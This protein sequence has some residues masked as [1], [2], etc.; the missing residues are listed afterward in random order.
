MPEPEARPGLTLPRW[1]KYSLGVFVVALAFYFLLSRLLRDWS[2]IPFSELHFSPWLLAL[3][4][5]VLIGTHLPLA[6][7]AW[8]LILKGLGEP[9]D[10]GR[11]I[12]VM[13]VTQLGKYVPG[14]LWF[15]LGR[16]SLLKSDSI[17]EAKTMVSVVVEI[18]LSLLAA[19]VLL[20]CAVILT[21]RA[22]V[23]DALYLAFLLVPVC[24]IVV[25]PRVLNRVLAY[26]LRRLKQP[27]FELRLTYRQLLA[28]TGLYL[29]DWTLQGVGSFILLNSFYPL[30]ITRL[31]VVLGGY[32]IS[33]MVGFLALVAPAGLGIREGIFTLI[34]KIVMPGP[35]AIIF[36]LL[37]RVWMTVS[38]AVVALVC[39]PLLN[40]RRRNETETQTR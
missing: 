19:L 5:A 18:V 11:A 31:P 3:S 34:L 13:S 30:P 25:Y 7:S 23:P 33:W 9:L 40:R 32:A 4:F 12:A 28:I 37:T 16:M 26:A 14:K 24:V 1:L 17:P 21:P 10:L 2:Q 39:L 29:A 38:E 22:L 6:G 35:V 8:G 20:G 36:T 27:I 15:T